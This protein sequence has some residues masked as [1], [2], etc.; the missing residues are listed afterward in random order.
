MVRVQREDPVHRAAQDRVDLVILGRDA[1]AHAQEVGRIVQIVARIHEGLTH[2]VL[3]GHGGNR[4]HLGD[5]A[6]RRDL[7]LPGIRDVGA[8]VVEGGHCADHAHHDR[9]RVRIAA[10]PGEET[11][12]LFVHHGVVSHAAF[13]VFQL[14]GG[15]QFTV[16]QQVADFEEMRLAGQLVDRVAPVQQH[17][18]FAVD[19]GD[20]AFAGRGR[21]EAR[22]IGEHV[23]L[24]IELADVQDI[25]ARAW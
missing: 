25:G 18:R 8:V 7:A 24:T 20:R 14:C 22:V 6:D 16:K 23:G 13:E 4:R 17:A 1:E 11:V 3:V 21:G 2:G 9:H 5:Q 19:I 10:E 12:H 15:R